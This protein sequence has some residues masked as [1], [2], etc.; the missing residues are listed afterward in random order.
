MQCLLVTDLGHF[1]CAVC[2]AGERLM[3]SWTLFRKCLRAHTRPL[4][5][6]QKRKCCK[7]PTVMCMTVVAGSWVVF[8]GGTVHPSTFCPYFILALRKKFA[9]QLCFKPS[10]Q[11][12]ETDY[13]ICAVLLTNENLYFYIQRIS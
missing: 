13:L 11:I 5:E 6:F 8:M 4:C 12:T 2:H 1:T 10:S 7:N 9:K 3:R